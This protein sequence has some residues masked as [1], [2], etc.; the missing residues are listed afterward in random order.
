[1]LLPRVLNLKA[2]LVD[3]S[4]A[5]MGLTHSAW[6]V[7][8]IV[9]RN[10]GKSTHALAELCF[11]TDQSFGQ[12]VSKLA[13]QGLVERRPG[14]GKAIVHE[15]TRE[16]EEVLARADPLMKR[17]LRELCSALSR[18]E[19]ETLARLLERMLV[20]SGDDRPAEPAKEG[21]TGR[22]ARK[23]RRPS[24]GASGGISC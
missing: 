1:M 12:M 4:L 9:S 8:K 7:L 17:A 24:G 2:A 13:Q 3:K 16:G 6:V 19:G 10:P 18:E 22:R 15:L 5:E 14:F 11:V 20:E 23:R 21:E